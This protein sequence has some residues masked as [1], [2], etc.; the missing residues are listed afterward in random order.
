MSTHSFARCGL[1]LVVAVATL[2]VGCAT[3]QLKVEKVASGASP[4]GQIYYLPRV[5]FAI[6]VEREL[7]ACGKVADPLSLKVESRV[8]VTPY[9]LPDLSAVYRIDYTHMRGR[10]K[11]TEYTLETYPNGTLKSLNTQLDDQ[12][13]DAIRG[14]LNGALRL[15][16]AAQTG[17]PPSVAANGELTSDTS[18]QTPQPELCNAQ[19]LGRLNERAELKQATAEQQNLLHK[20]EKRALDAEAQLAVA[21]Q[22]LANARIDNRSGAYLAKRKQDVEDALVAR[23]SALSARSTHKSAIAGSSE[24]LAQ[25]RKSLTVTG[26]H[27]F[28]P[29][30]REVSMPLQKPIEAGLGDAINAW[31][32]P[33]GD[34][35]VTC[36]SSSANSSDCAT[37]QLYVEVYLSPGDA[38]K[39]GCNG[40]TCN[41]GLVYRQPVEGMLMICAGKKCLNA[42][43]EIQVESTQILLMNKVSVPQLGFLSTLPLN[44][45]AFQN[46]SLQAAFAEDGTLTKV[47]Y[48]SN[49]RAVKQAN[50]FAESADSLLKFA[51]AK[52]TLPQDN[53]NAE[54]A[55]VQT[56]TQLAEATLALERANRELESF[57]SGESDGEADATEAE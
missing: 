40:S 53:L 16:T 42:E 54:L 8:K 38:R 57:R 15:A 6:E 9:V 48:S 20:A 50:V 56:R 14:Y 51:E 4:V 49:A 10:F 13:G 37:L 2:S 1:S 21:Q 52:R 47:S 18:K 19:T 41:S 22:A 44:N 36:G 33:V 28:R 43:G 27:H 32:E 5:E 3:T 39:K 17:P 29:S 11:A 25:V 31:I 26:V 30:L 45:K 24:R 55:K 35:Q 34:T 46:N 7:V 23:D 12:T